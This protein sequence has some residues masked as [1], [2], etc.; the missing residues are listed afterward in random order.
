MSRQPMNRVK[1]MIESDRL[2]FES[3]HYVIGRTYAA[4]VKI[5][6]YNELDLVFESLEGRHLEFNEL[7]YK[8]GEL[9]IDWSN[10]WDV[11]DV[12]DN[13]CTF[14]IVPVKSIPVDVLSARNS[15]YQTRLLNHNPNTKTTNFRVVNYNPETER[16]GLFERVAK[17]RENES[18]LD[19]EFR[20]ITACLAAFEA[21][22]KHSA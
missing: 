12:I 9:R 3:N 11:T 22:K 18:G 5:D 7:A 8:N 1:I 14:R 19:Y 6:S 15:A 20:I 21:I 16:K 13:H 17:Q 2:Y 4:P 10:R